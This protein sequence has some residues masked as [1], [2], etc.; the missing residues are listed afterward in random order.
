MKTA[1]CRVLLLAPTLAFALASCAAPRPPAGVTVQT[2]ARSTNSWNGAALPAYPRGQPEITILRIRIPPG[3]R[4]DTH[5]HPMINAGVLVSG[6][7]KVVT[8]DGA[9]HEL[10][11][12]DALIEVVDTWHYGTNEGKTPADIIV[13]YAGAAG[14]P[15]SVKK[16][17]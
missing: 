7:L 8:L 17:P 4:L 5:L 10:R 3:M 14:Q 9:T 1:T 15:T 12:G 6:Q 11:A 13:F 2:L 16:E